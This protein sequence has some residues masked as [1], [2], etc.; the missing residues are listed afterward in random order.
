MGA[1]NYVKSYIYIW[2]GP[3]RNGVLK[4]MRYICL[5]DSLC[6]LSF[7]SFH[8]FSFLLLCSVF[9][10]FPIISDFD[11]FFLI[12]YFFNFF[13]IY[14]EIWWDFLCINTTNNN[15]IQSTFKIKKK[16]KKTIKLK[17]CVMLV[18][19][20]LCV[21]ICMSSILDFDA[22]FILPSDKWCLYWIKPP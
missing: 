17:E 16:K 13:C 6:S 5:S 3:Q 14:V 9:L 8:F 2:R 20:L 4:W 19:F 12:F 15:V 7:L 11:L 22:S 1:V 10:F 18:S 21:F